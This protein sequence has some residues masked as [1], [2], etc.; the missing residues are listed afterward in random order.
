MYVHIACP[1]IVST[2]IA[3][4]KTILKRQYHQNFYFPELVTPQSLDYHNFVIF[5]S[6]KRFFLTGINGADDKFFASIV[7]ISDTFGDNFASI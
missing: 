1:Q 7:Y 6:S 4:S 5:K 2:I 3:Q